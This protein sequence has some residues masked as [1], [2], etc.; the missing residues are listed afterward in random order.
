MSYEPVTH[1]DWARC[2]PSSH[3]GLYFLGTRRARECGA[4]VAVFLA[5][6]FQ[7]VLSSRHV[8]TQFML[9]L[10]LIIISGCSV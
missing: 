3:V 5:T 8:R 2:F 4:F 6:V 7:H 10:F 1:L 9:R